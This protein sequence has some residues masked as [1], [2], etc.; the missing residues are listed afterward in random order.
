MRGNWLKLGLFGVAYLGLA[1]CL[2]PDAP[3]KPVL[4]PEEVRLPP[5]DDPRFSQPPTFPKETL[6][7][8]LISKDRNKDKEDGIPSN[9]RG[10]GRGGP[11]GY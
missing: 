4:P 2:T 9:F 11:G 8:G 10:P 1:G 3:P 5:A 7:Q 6:N